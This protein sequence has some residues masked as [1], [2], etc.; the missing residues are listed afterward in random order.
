MGTS[1]VEHLVAPLKGYVGY[2]VKFLK[3]CQGQTLQLIFR[4]ISDK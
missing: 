3:M 2:I 1:K 4:G